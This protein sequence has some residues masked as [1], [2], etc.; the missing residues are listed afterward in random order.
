MVKDLATHTVGTVVWPGTLL[1]TLHQVWV[2]NDD[3]GFVHPQQAFKL[4]PKAFEYQKYGMQDGWV[5]QVGADAADRPQ[6][7]AVRSLS[8][9]SSWI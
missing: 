1:L 3:I 6:G 7:R 2:R 5:R 4:K 9:G 8:R